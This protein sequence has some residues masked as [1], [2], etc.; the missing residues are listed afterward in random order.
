MRKS[1]RQSFPQEVK[2][3]KIITP[4]NSVLEEFLFEW[5]TCKNSCC[6]MDDEAEIS[7]I[8]HQRVS[9]MCCLLLTFQIA[10]MHSSNFTDLI[11]L[12]SC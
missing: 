5:H 4:K 7:V 2:T 10:D 9:P 11:F 1:L 3:Y 12:F 8:L 6:I